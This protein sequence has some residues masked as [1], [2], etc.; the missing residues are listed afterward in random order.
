MQRFDGDPSPALRKTVVVCKTCGITDS[1][2]SDLSVQ[3][4]KVKHSGHDVQGGEMPL[5]R[6]RQKGVPEPVPGRVEEPD[7]A[8]VSRVVVDL[9]HDPSSP[10]PMLRVR[11]YLDGVDEAFSFSS[12]EPSKVR[13]IVTKGNFVDRSGSGKL[14]IWE[15]YAVDYEDGT[16]D[17]LE[18]IPEASEEASEAKP[19]VVMEEPA[20]RLITIQEERQQPATPAP[21]SAKEG[22]EEEDV[23]LVSRSWYV[24]GGTR[25]REEALRVSQVLKGFRW[26]VEPIYT[27]GV[28][29]DDLL[30]IETSRNE[31]S[32]E[33]IMAVE[34]AGYRLSAITVEAGKLTAWFKRSM[35]RVE[36]S[37]GAED[38][39]L[40][41]EVARAATSTL[42]DGSQ[43]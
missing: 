39:G 28:V 16:R 38:G 17:Q 40:V 3:A 23:L 9:V 36:G 7:V 27:I 35:G 15:E 14:F 8:K 21:S 5:P 4:F 10:H 18:V 22:E 11:G 33:L 6:Q 29:V 26:K 43:N 41:D 34:A 42:P 12:E 25:N 24:Q 19:L 13:E 1:F 37:C 31:V 20:E 30:S 2:Y 32:R